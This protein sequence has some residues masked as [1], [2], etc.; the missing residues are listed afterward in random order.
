ME[1][2]KELEEV[3]EKLEEE[4]ANSIKKPKGENVYVIPVIKPITAPKV[5]EKAPDLEEL[6][7]ETINFEVDE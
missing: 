7:K 2:V 3:K 6:R 5:V 1:K 4:L